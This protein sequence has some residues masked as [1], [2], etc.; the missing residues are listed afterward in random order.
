[1]GRALLQENKGISNLDLHIIRVRAQTP[2]EDFSQAAA[3]AEE[4]SHIVSLSRA[5][6]CLF[7]QGLLEQLTLDVH[8][9]GLCLRGFLGC[10]LH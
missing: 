3:V 7:S 5:C 6:Q 4:G 8:G 10:L 1:M 2:K 9:V